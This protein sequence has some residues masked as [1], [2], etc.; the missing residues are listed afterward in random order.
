MLESGND[1][2]SV[3]LDFAKA[4]DKVDHALLY[5]KI[6]NLRI[7]GKVGAWLH[8]FLSNRTQQ[9]SA[10]GAIST[11]SPVLSGVPQGTVLGPVLFIIM[12]SDLDRPYLP[13]T[14]IALQSLHPM[15]MPK[16]SNKN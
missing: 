10:N 7:G 6:K 12:I 5:T 13:T 15:A 8:T 4:F 9:V 11:P 1:L 14:L 2:D 3:Y 16:I